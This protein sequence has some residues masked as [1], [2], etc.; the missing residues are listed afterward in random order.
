ML[1][2]LILSLEAPSL[3]MDII[4][5][6]TPQDIIKTKYLKTH[7]DSIMTSTKINIEEIK[8]LISIKEKVKKIAK[9]RN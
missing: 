3:K 6:F 9:N 7:D 8:K 2:V 1:L 4:N 5:F